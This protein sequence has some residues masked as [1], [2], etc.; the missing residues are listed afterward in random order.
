MSIARRLEVLEARAEDQVA[1]KEGVHRCDQHRPGGDVLR[2]PGDRVE[3]ARREVDRLLERGVEHLGDE[4]ERDRE[5]QRQHLEPARAED[6]AEREHGQGDEEVDAHVALRAHHVD[7]ALEGVVEARDQAAGLALGGRGRRGAAGGA[8]GLVAV[9]KDGRQPARPP[10]RWPVG[11]GAC[12][13]YRPRGRIPRGAG[14]RAR[15]GARSASRRP[16][17]RSGHTTT[18]PSWRG[19]PYGRASRPSSGNEGRRWARLL[20]RWAAFSCRLGE[21]D[22]PRPRP[23]RRSRPRPEASRPPRH[24]PPSS[25]TACPVPFSTSTLTV[26]RGRPRRSARR[27]RR[28][29][30]RSAGRACGERRRHRR[31][32]RTRRRGFRPERA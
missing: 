24:G 20:P 11:G 13:R 25:S 18:S 8:A 28:R 29:R 12:L 32:G 3:R 4:D 17:T 9:T 31:S 30:S 21:L 27:A 26:I 1:D 16:S 22:E 6:D 19:R 15:G 7:H 5:H 2:G 10:R 23:R 14:R